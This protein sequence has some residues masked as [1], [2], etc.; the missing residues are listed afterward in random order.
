M[1]GL[2]IFLMLSYVLIVLSVAMALLKVAGGITLQF[3]KEPIQ[4]ILLTIMLLGFLGSLMFLYLWIGYWFTSPGGFWQWDAVWRDI[5]DAFLNKGGFDGFVAFF[6]GGSIPMM[7]LSGT[8][9]GGYLSLKEKLAKKVSKK[10]T[11]KA[12]SSTGTQTPVANQ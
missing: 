4:F 10:A 1:V 7:I 5:E 3:L 8:V 2:A 11:G 12:D 6:T 9:L